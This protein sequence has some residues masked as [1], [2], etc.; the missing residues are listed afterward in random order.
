[1]VPVY[2]EHLAE[3]HIELDSIDI[4]ASNRIHLNKFGWFSKTASN[5]KLCLNKHATRVK[6]S[7]LNL[8]FSMNYPLVRIKKRQY[9]TVIKSFLILR[10]NIGQKGYRQT[11]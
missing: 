5:L 3:E 10:N 4:L 2:V 7:S 6:M 8:K 11:N 1:V 9:H